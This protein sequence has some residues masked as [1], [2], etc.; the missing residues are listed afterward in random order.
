MFV[1]NHYKIDSS[2][3]HAGWNELYLTRSDPDNARITPLQNLT[4]TLA[5]EFPSTPP[6]G[7]KGNVARRDMP[8]KR[9]L[10]GMEGISKQGGR[11]FLLFSR[12]CSMKRAPYSAPPLFPHI[13]PALP[14]AT[15]G[16]YGNSLTDATVPLL[17]VTKK[18]DASVAVSASPAEDRARDSNPGPNLKQNHNHSHDSKNASSSSVNDPLSVLTMHGG[19]KDSPVS[20]TAPRP[21]PLPQPQSRQQPT[22]DDKTIKKSYRKCGSRRHQCHL[23]P[24]SFSMSG[25]LNRHVNS[26]HKGMFLCGL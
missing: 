7:L 26:V 23:C 18:P 2:C 1:N 8:A 20:Q 10:E 21:L 24:A 9:K 12:F 25:H 11:V 19:T 16:E 15:P 3:W 4:K 22:T 17:P 14:T 5:A 6:S 13:P